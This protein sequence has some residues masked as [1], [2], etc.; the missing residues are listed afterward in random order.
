MVIGG[1]GGVWLAVAASVE[2]VTHVVV[3][4]GARPATCEKTESTVCNCV[5]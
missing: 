3:L 4:C 5:A 1:D 2:H